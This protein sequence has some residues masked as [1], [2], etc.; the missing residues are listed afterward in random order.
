MAVHWCGSV[1]TAVNPLRPDRN[2]GVLSPQMN[3]F[4]IRRIVESDCAID[5]A[6]A[7]SKTAK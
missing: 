4:S 3:Y 2:I 7:S 6:T 5:T 1:N